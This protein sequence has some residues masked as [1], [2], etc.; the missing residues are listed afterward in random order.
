VE[1]DIPPWL[2]NRFG[3]PVRDTAGEQKS[4]LSYLPSIPKFFGYDTSSSD[5]LTKSGK[6]ARSYVAKYTYSIKSTG[7]T[8]SAQHNKP[9]IRL[10]SLE[11][12]DRS[13]IKVGPPI[14]LDIF[15]DE[16]SDICIQCPVLDIDICASD[17]QEAYNQLCGYIFYLWDEFANEALNQMTG[18]AQHIAILMKNTFKEA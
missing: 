10:G 9:L 2:V 12:N 7:D 4:I 18:D 14:L 8:L 17:I 15:L 11:L 5:S 3:S 1:I 16:D 6:R 13:L